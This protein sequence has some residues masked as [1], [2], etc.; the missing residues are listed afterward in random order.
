MATPRPQLDGYQLLNKV[1]KALPQSTH[2]RISSRR[3]PN[4]GTADRG[5]GHPTWYAQTVYRLHQN[6]WIK[7]VWY[8][9]CSN[10]LDVIVQTKFHRVRPIDCTCLT[11]RWEISIQLDR[12][13][14][15]SDFVY[16][17][18][19]F[20]LL[21]SSS[22]TTSAPSVVILFGVPRNERCLTWFCSV[23]LFVCFL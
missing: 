11:C 16:A 21:S 5:H 12:L 6:I 22:S 13:P 17:T 23:A 2:D 14:L 15:F 18:L 1:K 19:R 9:C 10:P 8:A 20:N 4:Q 3:H 7:S